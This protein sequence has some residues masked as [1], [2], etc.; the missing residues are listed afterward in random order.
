M[1]LRQSPKTTLKNTQK[2]PLW[3]ILRLTFLEIFKNE[4]FHFSQYSRNFVSYLCLGFS[5]RITCFQISPRIFQLNRTVSALLYS[6]RHNSFTNY[7]TIWK[8]FVG[9]ENQNLHKCVEKLE[10]ELIMFKEKYEDLK[11]SKQEAVRELLQ[12]KDTHNDMLSHIKV[13]LLNETSFRE[14]VDRRLAD[15]RGQVSEKMGAIY[16]NVGN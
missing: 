11:I 16:R 1:F 14:D 7:G 13:D 10:S 8:I 2:L 5:D 6:S 4:S 12:L 15:V 9:S 3:S